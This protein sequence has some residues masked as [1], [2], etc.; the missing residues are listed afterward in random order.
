[1][2]PLVPLPDPDQMKGVAE[3]QLGENH[4]PLKQFEGQSNE[5]E[6]VTIFD[7][8]IIEARVVDAGTQGPILLTKEENPCPSG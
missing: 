8:D 2:I 6:G 4:S 7:G 5:L 3:I 1:M